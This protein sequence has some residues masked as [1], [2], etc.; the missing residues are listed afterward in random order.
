MRDFLRVFAYLKNYKRLVGLHILY[1]LLSVIFS[2]FTFAMVIPFLKITFGMQGIPAEPPPFRFSMEVMEQTIGYYLGGYIGQHGIMSALLNI[3]AGLVLMTF[4]RSFFTYIAMVMLA[5]IRNGVV[6]DIRNKLYRKILYLPMGYFSEEK[7][8]DLMA[9]ISGDVQEIENSVLSA[10]DAILRSPIQIVIYLAVMFFMSWQLTLV[11]VVLLPLSGY[12]IG[13]LGRSLRRTSRDAQNRF[14]SIMSI[15]EETL[16]GM[17]VIKAFVAEERIWIFFHGKNEA[18]TNV[19]NKIYRRRY[20]ASPM[21]EFL[22]VV[23]VAV[24]IYYGGFLIIGNAGYITGETF[25]AYIIIFSQIIPPAKSFTT[26]QYN[27]SKGLASADRVNAVLDTK[28]PITSNPGAVPVQGFADRIEY[29]DVVFRYGDEPVINGV[30]FTLKK[31]QTVALVGPSGS[32]KTT[33]ADLLPRFYD[34]TEGEVMVD[35]V[36]VRD[37]RLSDLRG[38]MGNVNQEPILFNDTIANNIAFG[39]EDAPME[40]IEAAARVANAHEFIMQTEQ[41]YETNIGDRGAKLSGGQRQRL[42]IARAVLKNPP[43][44]IL[45]EATSSLD[46]ESERLVQ[47]ALDNLMKE[48]TSLV[49]AHRLSTIRN[50]DR[51]LVIHEGQ[52][53][54]E[55]THDELIA[56]GGLYFKL[57]NMQTFQGS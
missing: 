9:R 20:L 23:T 33:L 57:Y 16:G 26:A 6:R 54:E 34:V 25:I 31:G 56:A 15:I 51:I 21:T 43:I 37:L 5:P 29:R 28:N 42:S 8:G 46:T 39:V 22:G 7:K 1:T 4:F 14:G 49:I 44:L 2:V 12:L 47:D 45:D 32:G 48:R 50:A 40:A 30:S 19:M 24:I 13:L 52:L 27:I 10:L 36:S 35:G 38:L 17:R 53:A 55:G 18:Y 3:V 41:G 11:A